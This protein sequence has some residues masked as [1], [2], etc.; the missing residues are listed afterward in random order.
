MLCRFRQ[1]MLHII[2]ETETIAEILF[3][4][5][6]DHVQ[7]MMDIIDP[8][9]CQINLLRRLSGGVGNEMMLA[10]HLVLR[11]FIQR[12]DVVQILRFKGRILLTDVIDHGVPYCRSSIGQK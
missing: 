12:N 9:L 10:P 6:L 4:S 11:Q 3:L 5:V 7:G 8:L 2:V 1:W